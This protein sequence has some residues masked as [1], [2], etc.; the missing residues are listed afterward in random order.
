MQ[1][2]QR[3]LSLLV[4]LPSFFNNIAPIKDK[5]PV[6]THEVGDTW[7]YGVPADPLKMSQHREIQR[8]WM[9]C[10]QR[11]DPSCDY[12]NPTIQN[13]TRF[14][15]KTPEHTWGIPGISGW[16]GGD[17]YAKSKLQPLLNMTDFLNAA[18]TWAEQR[19]YNEL[20]IRA[21]EWDHHP[22]ASEVRR[23]VSALSSVTTP[24]L[25][26]YIKVA[27]PFGQLKLQNNILLT[28]GN[29]GTLASLILK[30]V[31]WS[32]GGLGTFVYRTYNESD[33]VPFS[34]WYMN[35]GSEQGGFC[36][37]GSNPYSE[38][39]YFHGTVVAA[40]MAKDGSGVVAQVAMPDKAVSVYGSPNTVYL[41]W[42]FVA[43]AQGLAAEFN[44]IYLGKQSIMIGESISV[45][46]KPSPTRI[47]SWSIEK[48]GYPVDPEDVQDGGNQCNHVSWE[49]AALLTAAGNFTLKSFD[50]ANFNP[51]YPDYP[52]GNALPA[53]GPGMTQLP[54]GSVFGMAVNLENNLWNTNYP[55]M[56]PYYDPPY[57]KSVLDCADANQLF[58]F[59]VG[60]GV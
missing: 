15:M 19:F 30:N 26:N 53:G 40:Y 17:Q 59:K 27:N 46:F 43:Q 41:N 5:L 1:N 37:P 34:K 25:S 51:M 39:T 29:D 38:Q 6:V 9:E 18:S 13:M 11:G 24:D 36:K 8:V 31:E 21:L 48:L 45:A 44:L 54:R 4:P 3:L 14:L 12:D 7:I 2:T 23:R 28:F 35:G 52:F 16:G 58:R 60:F 50:A 20:A 22:L 49:G 10:L 57:C 56:N 33:W 32:N 42:T 47:G 55:L